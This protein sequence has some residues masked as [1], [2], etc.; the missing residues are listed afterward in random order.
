MSTLIVENLKGPTAGA[1]ANKITIPSGQ[2]LD[3]SGGTLVPSAGQV[4]QV[5]R[6]Y[7]TASVS[8]TNSSYTDVGSAS[9]TPSSA[10]NKIKVTVCGVYYANHTNSNTNNTFRVVRD[11]T[12]IDGYYWPVDSNGGAYIHYKQTAVNYLIFPPFSM[13]FLNSPSTTSSTTYTFQVKNTVSVA[14]IYGGFTIF[15]EEIAA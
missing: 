2:T 7:T 10:S 12:L 8:L 9:I 15:L 3:A 6:S 11:G 14:T 4:V 13:S 5:Q 1:N